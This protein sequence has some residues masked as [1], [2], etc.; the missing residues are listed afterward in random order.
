M[1]HSELTE[2]EPRF[3]ANEW[4]IMAVT[5]AGHLLC[6][7]GELA[8]AAVLVAVMMEFH[9]E[10]DRAAATAVPGFL[11]FG[12]CA[13]PAGIWTDRR[14][15]QQTMT[16]YFFLLGLT[17]WAVSAARSLWA[18][19]AA[20]ACLGAALSIYHPSGL[21][22]IAQ[23]CRRRGRA[24]G[25]NGVAGSLG[26]A[27]GP[28]M[29]LYF[30]S[31]H[32][33]RVTYAVLGTSS[34]LCG[35]AAYFLP[36]ELR[37]PATTAQSP[38]RAASGF[39][40]SILGLLFAAMLVSGFNYR[41]LTTALP[42]FLGNPASAKTVT[43]SATA[44]VGSHNTRDNHLVERSDGRAHRVFLVLA[45]GGLGQIAGG[46]LADRF[47]PAAVYVVIILATIPCALVMAYGPPMAI[48][49][50]AC[51][52]VIFQ[53]GQQPLENTMLAEATPIPWRSTV[54]G[55]KFILVFGV[56]SLGVYSTGIIWRFWGLSHVFEIFA[57][58]ALV[59]AG[60]AA[61]YAYR[62]RTDFRQPSHSHP[63]DPAADTR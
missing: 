18:L 16:A 62:S 52:L 15:S 49:S 39:S 42:T 58:L 27:L 56:G 5:S 54:Y 8:F 17:A 13:V 33:W 20:L 44:D 30:A 51:L 57:A 59:M 48:L 10:A 23:G 60:L 47:R 4:R 63:L 1:H 40:L 43:Q 61:I 45:L 12:A 50:A 19:T 22:M 11:L 7:M 34:L 35:V 29:G 37:P 53:F 24:M 46:F 31:H 2:S 6:H 32:Q 38:R 41:S 21:A 55:L 36:V 25:I 9:V 26:V 3:T 14:G 28:A